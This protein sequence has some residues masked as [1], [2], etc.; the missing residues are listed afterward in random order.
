MSI[1][2]ES[3]AVTKSMEFGRW[4]NNAGESYF[5]SAS[6]KDESHDY[7][8]TAQRVHVKLLHETTSFGYFGL[9]D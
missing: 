8:S 5:F 7:G 2:G 4:T 6:L 3:S 9:S 1:W